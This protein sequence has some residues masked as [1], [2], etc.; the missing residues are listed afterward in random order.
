MKKYSDTIYNME[1]TSLLTLNINKGGP[2][3]VEF[4]KMA[5]GIALKLLKIPCADKPDTENMPL[6][7]HNL[8]FSARSLKQTLVLQKS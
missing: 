6:F 3:L 8:S 2:D 1:Q 4:R 7:A 5:E